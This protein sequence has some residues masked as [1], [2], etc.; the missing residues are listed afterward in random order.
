MSD[1]GNHVHVTDTSMKENKENDREVVKNSANEL[2][3]V[4]SQIFYNEL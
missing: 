3:E 4:S 1:K 2:Y